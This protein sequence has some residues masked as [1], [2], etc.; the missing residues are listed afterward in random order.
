MS[1][2]LD[3][4]A[5]TPLAPEALAVMLPYFGRDFA[6]PSS[7][8]G[9]GRTA[10]EAVRNARL[11]MARCLGAHVDE[12]CFT[13]GGSAA[14]NLAILG[15]A[16][17]AGGGHVITSVV[18]H[19][20]V[21]GAVQ[22]LEETGFTA[23]RLP[24]D[25]EGFVHPTH[26]LDALRPDTFLVS[27]MYANNET[28]TMQPVAEIGRLLHEQG[29]LFHTDAVQAAGKVPFEV[30]DLR[31][32]L[33]S[34]SAHKFNGPKGIGALYI[35]K[36]TR[37]GPLVHGGGQEGGL[38]AGTTN[39]PGVVSMARALVL[40][41]EAMP[42]EPIRVQAL[43]DR[44]EERLG[45]CLAIRRNGPKDMRLPNTLNLTFEGVESAALLKTLDEKRVHVSGGAA[46]H[47]GSPSPVLEAMGA[48]DGPPG[49]VLRFSLGSNTTEAEIVRAAEIV[50][51]AVE[52]L[53]KS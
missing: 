20:S 41:H 21:L 38:L 18:E 14:N 8:H 3:H 12:I 34:L 9:P 39:V 13:P 31:V 44:L 6:N 43:R 40:R 7:A 1:I 25:S 23:T 51:Q 29:I 11:A 10:A 35:R 47:A 53:S 27:I 36:G 19:P 16:A 48:L 50:I 24:V 26:V 17:S 22:R 46:C 28:G 33:L 42:D 4:N 37:L 45:A 5:T 52:E 49:A 32:G 15:A 2:Y 30:R